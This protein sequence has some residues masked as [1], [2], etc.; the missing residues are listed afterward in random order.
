MHE[1]SSGGGGMQAVLPERVEA[2]LADD[3]RKAGCLIQ[4]S[5]SKNKNIY[6]TAFQ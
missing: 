5:G 6:S 1:C 2:T 4:I 3:D